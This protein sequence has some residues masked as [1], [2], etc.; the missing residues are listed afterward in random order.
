MHIRIVSVGAVKDKHVQALVEK[1]LQRIQPFAKLEHNVL[2]N[3]PDWESKL[4]TNTIILDERGESMRSEALAV[5][6]KE[7]TSDGTPITFAIG[8][9]EGF[10]NAAKEKFASLQLSRFTFPHEFALLLL[11]EQIY[12][13]CMINNNRKYHKD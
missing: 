12:R 13:S 7:I 1:Y 8:P 10:S 5:K 9:A 6:M 2:K 11:V 3:S 4:P